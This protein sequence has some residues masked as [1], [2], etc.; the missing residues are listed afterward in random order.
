MAG[1]DSLFL[2]FFSFTFIGSMNR[3]YWRVAYSQASSKPVSGAAALGFEGAYSCDRGY[4]NVICC[5]GIICQCIVRVYEG[6]A[7]TT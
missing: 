6:M 5:S 2:V 3:V 4:S 1:S 7:A